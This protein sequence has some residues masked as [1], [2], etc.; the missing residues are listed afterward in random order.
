MRTY[1]NGGKTPYDAAIDAIVSDLRTPPPQA[2]MMAVFG[3]WGSGK[4]TALAFAAEQLA[5]DGARPGASQTKIEVFD[6]WEHRFSSDPVLSVLA[7]LVQP[8]LSM[9]WTAELSPEVKDQI[10][11]EV[12]GR[13]GRYLSFLSRA[14]Q[15]PGAK[16][17]RDD[18]IALRENQ[19]Q[20]DP[21][22]AA[23]IQLEEH[24]YSRMVYAQR[25][26]FFAEVEKIAFTKRSLGTSDRLWVVIDNLDRCPAGILLDLLESFQSANGLEKV[27]L[28]FALDPHAAANAIRSRYPSFSQDDALA[29]LEKIFFPI[30][31]MP[32]LSRQ[33]L[34]Q[35][36]VA[37]HADT[38]LK[39]LD[40]QGALGGVNVANIAHL[41][42]T[43]FA[44]NARKSI[45]FLHQYRSWATQFSSVVKIPIDGD[46]N[47]TAFAIAITGWQPEIAG[48]IAKDPGYTSRLVGKSNPK[49]LSGFVELDPQH[50]LRESVLN[51]PETNPYAQ[52]AINQPNIVRAM[53]SLQKQ[54]EA[55]NSNNRAHKVAIAI[56]QVLSQLT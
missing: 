4:S 29:Y 24:A 33:D 40:K 44:G 17:L 19:A 37:N 5:K 12:R 39:L 41:C 54:G 6:A 22:F 49:F 50:F 53:G 38:I 20:L 45:H 15:G 2:R 16:E 42:M 26:K 18:E 35:V 8:D 23:K 14:L 10:L 3:A 46:A 56:K 34:I 9:D 11:V 25:T 48:L 7:N 31:W 27:R 30:H 47:C 52:L 1:V 21:R 32:Q 13:G 43:L 36:L 55:D 28:L 51:T